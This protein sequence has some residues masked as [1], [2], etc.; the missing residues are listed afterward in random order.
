MENANIVNKTAEARMAKYFRKMRDADSM[1]DFRHS[2]ITL[3]GNRASDKTGKHFASK[4]L[5]SKGGVFTRMQDG[6]HLKPSK[7][8]DS[9]K[10]MREYFHAGKPRDSLSHTL[11]Q[12]KTNPGSTGHSLKALQTRAKQK[13]K[14]IGERLEKKRNTPKL[15]Q[16]DQAE[17]IRKIMSKTALKNTNFLD[18]KY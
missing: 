6:S 3:L 13:I 18:G 9:I 5:S 7:V 2:G 11:I 15:S 10:R 14:E 4:V 17:K 16:E 8:E 12:E 1:F